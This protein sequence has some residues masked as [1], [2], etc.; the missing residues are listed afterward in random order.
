MKKNVTLFKTKKEKQEKITM[1][2]CYDY[3]TARFLQQSDI[4]SILIGDSLGMVFQ[5]NDETLPVTVDEIIYHTKTVRRGAPDTFIIGDMPFLSYHVSV[6]DAVFN[7]GRMVKEGGAHAV[8]VEGGEEMVQTIQAMIAAKIPVMGHLG[9][10]PQSINIF[11]GHR[12]Q[13]KTEEQ[14]K[15]LLQDAKL[16]EQAGVFAIVLECVP[17]KLAKIIT[18]SIGI[19]TIGIGSGVHCDGQVLVINDILGM[20]PEMT[21]KF[22]KQFADVGGQIKKGIEGYITEVKNGT[23]PSKEHTFKIDDEIIERLY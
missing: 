3:S 12:V 4:D 17:E 1:L 2:T 13:G 18:G 10:T 14:A 9:L 16:L 20:Y 8:K 6:P 22:V 21:P 7:A 15:K 5:G 11:G 23:F 19:P